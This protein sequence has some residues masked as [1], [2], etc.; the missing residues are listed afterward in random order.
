[1]DR[2]A[3]SSTGT[4]V[5]AAALLLGLIMTSSLSGMGIGSVLTPE[6]EAFAQDLGEAV[7]EG[8]SSEV[9]SALSDAFEDVD[10]VAS[11]KV[12]FGEDGSADW[13]GD[14]KA[15]HEV[16]VTIEHDGEEVGTLSVGFTKSRV[17]PLLEA[18][19]GSLR[20]VLGGLLAILAIAIFGLS[21]STQ[22]E[23]S[24]EMGFDA[25]PSDQSSRIRDT[26]A[27]LG[28]SIGVAQHST[29]QVMSG[30]TGIM[31]GSEEVA[32]QA[33][34]VTVNST[35]M[36]VTVGEVSEG[37]SGLGQSVAQIAQNVA[38]ATEVARQAA[39]A[40]Q[41]A[42]TI[43][44]ALG[45]RGLEIRQVIQDINTVA[46]Q[47]NLLALNAT[48][49][50][51]RAG[52]AG[53]GFAVVANEVKELSGQTKRATEDI[54]GKVSAIQ[55]G[56]MSAVEAIN[57]M[58]SVIDDIN[59]YQGTI[60]AAVEQQRSMTGEIEMKLQDAGHTNDQT[61]GMIINLSSEARSMA[62]RVSSIQDNV[63]ELNGTLRSLS[64]DLARV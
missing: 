41:E 11:A 44:A 53:K 39:E 63:T 40:A 17:E 34:T 60:S 29:E 23:P 58:V 57:R 26:V 10:G 54:R 50:A 52:E 33:S 1:M 9:E 8:D 46:E 7:A 49:E 24:A 3:L 14:G 59:S 13:S 5:V 20:V 4:L 28:S 38:E 56:T 47:T 30:V 6:A 25:G 27:S 35:Q 19:G 15:A 43:V 64:D 51:A 21:G 18:A 12:A 61:T 22:Q 32:S 62:E 45:Q 42:T 2:I 55:E 37:L 31:A 16:S 36:S 48:I